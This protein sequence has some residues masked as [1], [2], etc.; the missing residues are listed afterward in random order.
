[1]QTRELC[2]GSVLQERAAGASSLVC[3]GLYG[4]LIS[5]NKVLFQTTLK[6]SRKREEWDKGLNVSPKYNL[7]LWQVFRDYSVLFTLYNTGEL[8]C[9]WMG[10]NG[11][12]AK[13]EN[14]CFIV[15]CSRCRQNLKFGDFTLLFCG[16]RQRN[17]RKFVLHV[18]HVYFSFFNQS[19]S[20]FVAL[21]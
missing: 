20:C 2:S 10:A 4:A 6:C 12:K 11:F 15:I 16:V 9:N 5:C 18:Q 13:T 14:D 21:P 3:T 17:A 1:M 19:Y 8:S 7:A